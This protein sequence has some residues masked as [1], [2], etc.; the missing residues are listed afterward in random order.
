L[1]TFF[2][3][4]LLLVG[5]VLISFMSLMFDFGTAVVLAGQPRQ[6]QLRRQ[7]LGIS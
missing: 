7:Y 1:R 4:E 3:F 6:C 5:V 2:E